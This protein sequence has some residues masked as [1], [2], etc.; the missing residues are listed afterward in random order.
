MAA[1]TI[2]LDSNGRLDLVGA[3]EAHLILGVERSRIARLLHDNARGKQKVA[4]PLAE[5]QC[6]PIWLRS[7]IEETAR[8]M[9]DAAS[10]PYGDDEAGFD[11]WIVERARKRAESLPLTDEQLEAIIRRPLAVA[12]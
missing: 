9:Y 3:Y 2:T 1:R 5:L 7:Q 8:E 11:R 6:G 10:T 12:A 4:E